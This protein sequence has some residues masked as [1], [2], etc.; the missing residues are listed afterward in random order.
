MTSIACQQAQADDEHRPA[1]PELEGERPS[2]V[3]QFLL[4]GEDQTSRGDRDL[5]FALDP[6]ERVQRAGCLLDASRVGDCRGYPGERAQQDEKN[7]RNRHCKQ[8]E[9]VALARD[10]GF[11]LVAAAPRVHERRRTSCEPDDRQ[12]GAHAEVEHRVR[13]QRRRHLV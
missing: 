5:T 8:V 12:A 10:D 3:L 6:V 1:Q 2:C 9:G 11:E 7:E 13:P 4:E